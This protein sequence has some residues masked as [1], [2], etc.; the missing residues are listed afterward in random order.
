MINIKDIRE[1]LKRNPEPQEVTDMRNMITNS[2]NK[3]EFVEEGHKYYLPMPDGTKKSLKSVS[4]FTHQFEPEE[5]WDKIKL[6]YAIKHNRT[7]EDVDKE[8]HIKNIISTTRGTKTHFYGEMMANLFLGKEDLV[9]ESLPMSWEDGYL[10]PYC[11][12]EEAV[13]SFW[14]ELLAIDD[15][16]VVMPETKVYTNMNNKYDFKCGIAGTF[17]LLLACRVKGKIVYVIADY[18]TNKDLYNSYNSMHNKMLL[19]P[20]SDLVIEPKSMYTLQQ[21]TYQAMLQ[22]LEIEIVDRRLIWLKD[23][24]TYSKVTVPDITDRIL[25]FCC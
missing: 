1:K 13:E 3:L 8:W 15:V 6:D 25:N 2:F 16:W 5:D 23:D 14:E 24:G 17:D 12:K 20:F 11:A 18:K 21:S 10:L 19:P 22:Q 4:A 7:V 9:R